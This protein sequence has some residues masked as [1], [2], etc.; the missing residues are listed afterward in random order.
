MRLCPDARGLRGPWPA[1]AAPA[2]AV[3]VKGTEPLA[4]GV[5][6]Q[7]GLPKWVAGREVCS[8]SARRARARPRLPVAATPASPAPSA[9][10]FNAAIRRQGESSAPGLGL[11]RHRPRGRDRAQAPPLRPGDRGRPFRDAPCPRLLA[12]RRRGPSEAWGDRGPRPTPLSHP[13]GVLES[14]WGDLHP[15]TALRPRTAFQ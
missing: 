11:R 13:P 2:H 1:H 9:K 4:L 5:S 8:R 7:P 14:E 10:F 15:T 3:R 6:P 12:G